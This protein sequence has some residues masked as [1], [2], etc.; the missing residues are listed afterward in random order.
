M[1]RA[2]KALQ[3]CIIKSVSIETR[4]KAT[5]HE[6]TLLKATVARY[7]CMLQFHCYYSK[8]LVEWK[9][10]S[11]TNCARG[12]NFKMAEYAIVGASTAVI[13]LVLKAKRKKLHRNRKIWV[14]EWIKSRTE[15]GAYNQLLQELKIMDTSSYRN[16][17]RMDSNSFEMLLNAVAPLIVHEDTTMR[18]AIPPGERLAVTLRFLATG[19][20]YES[21][22]FLYRI[23]G[24][25]KQL[26]KSFLKLAVPY[27]KFYSQYL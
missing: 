9:S 21:L 2:K 13:V 4:I 16:F 20:S 10:H 26:V 1:N 23:P 12:Q 22:K 7:S 25:P 14:K 5:I 6:A 15:H 11:R 27:I 17:L 3:E 8:Q 24:Q 19:E 18:P